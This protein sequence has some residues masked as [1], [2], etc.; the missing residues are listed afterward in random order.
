MIEGR[1]Q[2]RKQR[3]SCKDEKKTSSESQK[4]EQISECRGLMLKTK[5]N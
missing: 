2:G 4:L 1:E 5:D 3:F